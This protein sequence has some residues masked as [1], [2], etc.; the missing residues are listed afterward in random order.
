MRALLSPS[1]PPSLWEY[2]N[3]PSCV[4][5]TSIQAQGTQSAEQSLCLWEYWDCVLELSFLLLG[6][7]HTGLQ[8]Q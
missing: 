8:A 5:S 7:Y 6:L 2:G 3:E 4:A 1:L